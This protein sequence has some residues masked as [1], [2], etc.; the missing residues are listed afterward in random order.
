[1][2]I[3]SLL[4]EDDLGKVRTGQRKDQGAGPMALLKQQ[5][6]PTQKGT[7]FKL[8]TVRGSIRLFFTRLRNGQSGG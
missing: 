7:W 5:K 6:V 4:I 2:M 3:V 8:L 1:M